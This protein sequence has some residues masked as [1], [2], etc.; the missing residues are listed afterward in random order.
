MTIIDTIVSDVRRRLARRSAERPLA[1]V[2]AAARSAPS[3]RGFID[4]LAKVPF[5]V[6]AEHK[7][8]SPS[9]G[10]M[11][12]ANCA[13]AFEV[14]A[15][16]AWVSA[17]SVLTEADHFDGSLEDLERGRGITGKPVLRKDF[18]VDPYQ[19]WEARAAGA[20]AVLLMTT[21]HRETPSLLAE[22]HALV[23]ELG[24]DALVE[25]GVEDDDPRAQL[26]IVPP[27]AR[28]LGV[29]ARRFNSGDALPVGSPA[30]TDVT[31]DTRRHRELRALIGPGKL[32][33]AESGIHT[34]RDLAAAKELGYAAGLIGTA[35]LK[36]PRTIDA[37]VRE[38][39]SAF[40]SC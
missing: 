35:F 29:N 37:V 39:A 13:R 1:E 25:L 20:D 8:R 11:S 40:G 24:M 3:P 2:K 34:A 36:G 19:V 7:R 4:A 31:T 16:L 26:P 14:Y 6:I 28:L 38:L 21:L 22:L 18:I 27:S 30:Q 12:E 23:E 9:G 10:P 15:E 17:I 33:V 32:A 5:S